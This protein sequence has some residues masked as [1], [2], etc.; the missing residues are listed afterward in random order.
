MG[1]TP[2]PLE[3]ETLHITPLGLLRRSIRRLADGTGFEGGGR[4]LCLRRRPDGRQLALERDD[5]LLP[6][7]DTLFQPPRRSSVTCLTRH[8]VKPLWIKY[9]TPPTNEESEEEV[10]AVDKNIEHYL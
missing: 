4:V 1:G 3:Q 5:P 8:V 7:I 9:F 2:S 10:T 6:V